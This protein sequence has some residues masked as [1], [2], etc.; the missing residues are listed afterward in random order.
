MSRK[1]LLVEYNTLC[2]KIKQVEARE[3]DALCLSVHRLD[4]EDMLDLMVLRHSL[5]DK[6]AAVLRQLNKPNLIKRLGK[7]VRRK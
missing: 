5:E 4:H 3:F 2:T 1:A 6:R 7:V